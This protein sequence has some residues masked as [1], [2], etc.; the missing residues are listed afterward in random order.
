MN[1]VSPVR[2]TISW[3]VP[4]LR[5]IFFARKN[6]RAMLIACAICVGV[7]ISSG[8]N[9]QR[10]AETIP[11]GANPRAGRYLRVDDATIYYEAYGSGGTPLVLLHGGLYGYIDEFGELI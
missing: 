4:H 11:Y 3:M 5:R 1:N 9:A 8:A 2:I 6:S 7:P 10:P